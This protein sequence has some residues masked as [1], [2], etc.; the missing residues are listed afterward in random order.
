MSLS[1]CRGYRLGLRPLSSPDVTPEPDLP[2]R[3]GPGPGGPS[4]PAATWSHWRC[5]GLGLCPASLPDSLRLHL[6]PP[7]ESEQS[8]S[9]SLWRGHRDCSG[10]ERSASHYGRCTSEHWMTV[11]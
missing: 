4:V 11:T 5:D 2:Q 7:P 1:D 3:R 9:E 8:E 6:Q 10:T